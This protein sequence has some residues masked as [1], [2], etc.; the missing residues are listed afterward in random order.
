MDQFAPEA[1]P[2]GAGRLHIG[3]LVN[4]FAALPERF[5]VRQAPV[6]VKQ[7]RLLCFN[8][9]L[10]LE[11]GLDMRG[12]KEDDLAALFAG[13]LLPQGGEPI[14]MAYAGHQFGNFVPQLG[15]G[16]ALLLGEVIDRAGRRRDIQ[17]KGSGR[18]AFSRGGDG[19]AALGPVLREYLISE[20]M[21]RLGIPATRALAAVLTGETVMRE[22]FLPGAVL[23][24]VLASNIRIGT[25]Q[26]FA[27]RG[28][29]EAIRQLADY[30][31][32]RHYP[33]LASSPGP[34][35][36]LLSRVIENQA[37]LVAQ[38]L[39]VGFIHGVMNT[40]NM[41]ISGETIDFGPCAF[42]DAYDP[43][44][45]FSSI[46]SAGRYAYGNQPYIAQW[47][48]ARF[49]ET[50]LPLID[51]D[52]QS[53]IDK[54]TEAVGRFSAAFQDAWLRGMRE[55][56]GLFHE[57]T[58]DAR[59][60]QDLLECLHRE[61]VDFTAFFRRLC[62]LAAALDDSAAAPDYRAVTGLFASAEAFM[63]WAER[64]RARLR[65]E[66]TDR[67]ALAAAMRLKNPAFIPRNYWVEQALA[68]AMAGDMQPFDR[69]F[70]V[71][72]NPY[73]AQPAFAQ[74]EGPPPPA[75]KPYITF[76]G[77]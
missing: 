22:T 11:L 45:V 70:A 77:T 18:T 19:R 2:G 68:A 43:G 7:P 17:F 75:D 1:G 72:Q 44:A 33:E 20:A 14:A 54:A 39:N 13:N 42:M 57:E 41:A 38:W 48:L 36:A 5:F 66:T 10:A 61:A 16:R 12:L 31:I 62:D 59:L 55:K 34:Y 76:C 50:L 4:S 65:A 52:Q 6:P 23:T 46:D 64:W 29:A 74:F 40:D 49:A 60:I 30:A 9:P 47:N 37:V 25:F 3:E 28:D 26:Y 15:D 53:A 35:L 63:P 24:R 32:A 73:E 21:H 8:E 69:L 67:D 71:L 56:L 58:G 51:L 27:V